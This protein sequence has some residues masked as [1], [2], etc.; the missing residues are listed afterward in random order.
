M[1]DY[2]LKYY[3]GPVS[4]YV[5]AKITECEKV[6]DTEAEAKA[7]INEQRLLAEQGLRAWWPY[8]GYTFKRVR[9]Y[10]EV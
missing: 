6:C 3:V 2:K 7:W 9:H 10:G 4:R 8:R 5:G 1:S